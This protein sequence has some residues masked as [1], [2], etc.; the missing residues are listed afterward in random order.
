MTNDNQDYI[1]ASSDN[2]FTP[3]QQAA[4][5]QDINDMN[6]GRAILDKMVSDLAEGLGVTTVEL[7][8]VLQEYLEQQNNEA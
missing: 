6:E 4:F 2:K 1:I 3:E 7:C 5:E 8:K